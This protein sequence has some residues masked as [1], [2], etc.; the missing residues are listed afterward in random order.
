MNDFHFLFS[1]CC[2]S[3]QRKQIRLILDISAE[4]IVNFGQ[5]EGNFL[6]TLERKVLETQNKGF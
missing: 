6:L 5:G 2:W 4:E 3:P 1:K